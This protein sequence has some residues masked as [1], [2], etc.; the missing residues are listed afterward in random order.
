MV[1]LKQWLRRYKHVAHL[2]AFLLIVIA[3]GALYP[4]AQQGVITWIWILIASIV[5][6]N[7]L[8]ISAD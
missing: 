4:A 5:F 2:V 7:I 6:G 3:S 1:T 8:V